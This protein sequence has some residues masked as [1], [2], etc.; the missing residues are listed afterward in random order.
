[1]AA[2]RQACPGRLT[3]AR[4][5]GRVRLLGVPPRDGLRARTRKPRAPGGANLV[6]LAGRTPF[7]AALLALAGTTGTTQE[8]RMDREGGRC[9][10]RER[11]LGSRPGR[12]PRRDQGAGA[13]ARTGHSQGRTG[14]RARAARRA[15]EGSL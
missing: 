1:M 5:A 10:A 15:L 3:P 9:A 4:P 2:L 11:Y 7:A 13:S 8:E 14:R 6:R 12:P